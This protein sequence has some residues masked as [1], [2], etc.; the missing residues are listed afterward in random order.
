MKNDKN[1]SRESDKSIFEVASGFVNRA[2]GLAELAPGAEVVRGKVRE[3]EDRLLTHLW[4]RMNAA[5]PALEAPAPVHDT[6]TPIASSGT[7]AGDSAAPRSVAE[8]G[9]ALM[10]RSLNQTPD[11]AI[12]DYASRVLNQ[13]V[14]DEMRILSATSDGSGIPCC[15]L[16]ARGRMGGG[17][18]M[19]ALL[20]RA[21]NQAGAMLVEATSYYLGHLLAVGLLAVAPPDPDAKQAYEMIENDGEVM[22]MAARIEKEMKMRPRFVHYTVTL[23]ALGS[24]FMKAINGQAE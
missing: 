3:A 24:R 14:P 8:R 16:E 4:V 2:R 10:E 6:E 9:Q 22:A 5:A 23:S 17:M 20:S 18:R 1:D 15:D 19:H 11:S 21:G 12:T 7:S 13:L